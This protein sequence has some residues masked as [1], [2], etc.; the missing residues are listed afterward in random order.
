[1]G[2]C[3]A[4][5]LQD[6][7]DPEYQKQQ[8]GGANDSEDDAPGRQGRG[9]SLVS[10][11]EMVAGAKRHA[12]PQSGHNIDDSSSDDD[13]PVLDRSHYERAKQHLQ[14]TRHAKVAKKKGRG[15][16]ASFF[17]FGGGGGGG[18]GSDG[19]A[20]AAGGGGAATSGGRSGRHRGAMAAGGDDSPRGGSAGYVAGAEDFSWSKVYHRGWLYK[21][22]GHF[23][24]R[25]NW[26]LRYFVLKGATLSYY[27]DKDDASPRGMIG[28]VGCR[29]NVVKEGVKPGRYQFEIHGAGKDDK[30]RQFYTTEMGEM[31][32]WAERLKTVI[33]SAEEEKRVA[34]DGRREARESLVLKV[35]GYLQKKGAGSLGVQRRWKKRYFML[36]R[37]QLFYFQKEGA[38]FP[39]GVIDLTGTS[40]RK[41]PNSGSEHQFQIWHPSRREFNLRADSA[42][43]MSM[44]FTSITYH[45]T[46]YADRLHDR[47]AD[48]ASSKGGGGRGGGGGGGGGGHELSDSD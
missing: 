32:R 24:R 25:R 18:S 35:E 42:D 45:A 11:Y 2:T 26:K 7:A 17:G 48:F 4:S 34:E 16:A 29:V 10:R 5:C 39:K 47:T 31:V 15:V 9:I 44:W 38:D 30:P 36:K 43:D 28:L 27:E 8:D 6:D 41:A 22:G 33:V 37:N 14:T 3:L 21:K 1:M 46:H 23:G 13:G 20:S 19:A 12:G 40:V